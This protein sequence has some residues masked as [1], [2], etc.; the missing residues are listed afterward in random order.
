MGF[1]AER[2]L[3]EPRERG[4][5]RDERTAE[6]G[7]RRQMMEQQ[8]GERRKTAARNCVGREIQQTGLGQCGDFPA[9]KSAKPCPSI[10]SGH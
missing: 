5:Q 2:D 3:R 1:A 6:D 10:S 8:S 9:Q 7:Q 4:N